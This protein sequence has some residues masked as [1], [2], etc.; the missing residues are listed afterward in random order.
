MTAA[1]GRNRARRCRGLGSVQ[2]A[3]GRRRGVRLQVEGALHRDLRQRTARSIRS[4]RTRS[5]RTATGCCVRSARRSTSAPAS[6]TTSLAG[7]RP[8]HGR[9]SLGL[10]S[11]ARSAASPRAC[12]SVSPG[13]RRR[14]VSPHPPSD[15]RAALRPEVQRIVDRAFE[16]PNPSRLRRTHAVVVVHDGEIVAE[17]YAR[18]VG[19][20]TPLPGWS[21]AKSVLNALIGILVDD[22]RLSIDSRELLPAWRSP[23]PRAAISLEDLLRMRSGLR[24][25]EAYSNPWSDVVQMLFN[26][27]DTAAYASQAAVERPSGIGLE[28]CERH[29]E[30][31][32]RNRPPNRRRIRLRELAETRAVRPA[33]DAKRDRGARRVGHVRVL[34]VHAGDGARLGAIRSVVGGRRTSRRKRDPV[35]GLD[36]VQHHADGPIARR[37]VRR[38]LVAEAEPGDRRRAPP[39]QPRSPEMHSL[40]SDTKGRR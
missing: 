32:V 33:R 30:H 5:P 27:P 17:R 15:P 29:D 7:L 20:D 6:V 39:R 19:A 38:A 9:L 36:P 31:P 18:G 4:T 3:H 21:M 2:A 1:I 35:E 28:L 10:G 12:R 13:R 22:G 40:R 34:V 8:A 11:D 23:D 24:F 37:P 14:L 25:S 16:E 26:V